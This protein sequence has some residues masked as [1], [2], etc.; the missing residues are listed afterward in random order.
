MVGI[1]RKL[2]RESQQFS[3]LRG[4]TQ[5]LDTLGLVT[6]RSGSTS[7]VLRESVAGMDVQGANV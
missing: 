7:P 3:Y 4:K 6:P 5:V 1:Q 2:T